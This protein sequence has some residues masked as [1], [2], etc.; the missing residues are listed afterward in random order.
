MGCVAKARTT[1]TKTD[2]KVAIAYL[3]VST[4]EQ[5]LGPEA[6]RAAIES[7]ARGAGVEVVSWHEDR[8]VSGAAAIE[9]RPALLAALDALEAHSAGVLAVAKRDRLARDVM[10]AAM[11]ERLAA[12]A[13]ARIVSAAGEGSDSDDPA[14]MLMRSMI[15]AFAAYERQIIRQRTKA[16]MAVKKS[17]GERVGT[18]PL[19]FRLAADGRTLEP[20]A[21]ETEALELARELRAAGMSY[22]AIGAALEARGYRARAGAWHS[23]TIMRALAA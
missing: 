3:R 7:W 18:V 23:M 16:A 5:D 21:H 8:G 11:I 1:K 9:D 12:R 4:A 20:D 22:R 17:R 15:D 14:S 2:A 13:G 6:Q 19:G 10:S